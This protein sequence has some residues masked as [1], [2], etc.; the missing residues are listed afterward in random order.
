MAVSF[1]SEAVKLRE[2]AVR[3]AGLEMQEPQQMAVFWF[4]SAATLT[5]EKGWKP[6]MVDLKSGAPMEIGGGYDYTQAID[7][8]TWTIT[9]VA[10]APGSRVRVVAKREATT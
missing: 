2:L 1:S 9:F 8:F 7:G 6:F 10:G 4:A 3:V 5:L